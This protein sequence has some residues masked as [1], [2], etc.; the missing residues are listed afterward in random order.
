MKNVI[1]DCDDQ[2][3]SE[4]MADVLPL[5][6]SNK[7]ALKKTAIDD[8]CLQ[9]RRE[10][11]ALSKDEINSSLSLVL[12]QQLHAEDWLSFKHDGI[13]TGVFKNLR[14]GKYPPETTLNLFN[15]TPAQAR[16]ELLIFIQDCQ[17][18]NIRSVLIRFGRGK[19][20]GELIKSY[21][22]QWLPIVESVQAFHTALKHH[23]GSG[24]IYVLFRKSEQKRQQNRECHAARMG[25]LLW[26]QPIR[27]LI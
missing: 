23:G 21:L 22:S 27:P 8:P 17:E 14:L 19:H 1:T 3:F 13:Q 15:K 10:R 24:A 4:E 25:S 12:K 5:K 18:L 6:P 20:R 7:V 9:Y 26:E 2:L 11:A 16:D